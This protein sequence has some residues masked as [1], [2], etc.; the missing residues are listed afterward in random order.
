MYKPL[1]FIVIVQTC[2]VFAPSEEL[3]HILKFG[4]GKEIRRGLQTLFMY[5]YDIHW[6]FRLIRSSEKTRGYVIEISNE[7]ETHPPRESS[8]RSSAKLDTLSW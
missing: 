3:F 2:G 7:F 4:L 1:R 8:H 6:L 5:A